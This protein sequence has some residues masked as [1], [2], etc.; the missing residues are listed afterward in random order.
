MAKLSVDDVLKF[1]RLARISLSKEELELFSIELTSILD[2]VE[3]LNNV[4]LENYEPTV[5][6]SE[7]SRTSRPDEII[8]Y[9]ASPDD[10]LENVPSKDGRYIKVKRIL[11]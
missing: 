6:V 10:L 8:P 9:N 7:P 3:Q 2:Y 1:A 11:K 4:D 5:Q